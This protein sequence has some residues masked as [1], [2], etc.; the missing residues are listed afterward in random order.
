MTVNETCKYVLKVW[1]T[2][3]ICGSILTFSILTTL[4]TFASE[5]KS[6]I[7]LVTTSFTVTLIATLVTIPVILIFYILTETLVRQKLTNTFIKGVLVFIASVLI[8]TFFVFVF[9]QGTDFLWTYSSTTIFFY[10]YFSVLTVSIIGYKLNR[11]SKV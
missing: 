2:T 10:C 4:T 5:I 7:D 6:L 11:V 8:F 3:I 1:A 9:E